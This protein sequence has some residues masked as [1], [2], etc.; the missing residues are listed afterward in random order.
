[1]KISRII[2]STTIASIAMI[3]LAACDPPMPPEVRAVQDE[4]QYTCVDGAVN[5]LA[6]ENMTDIALGWSDSL[7]YNCVDPEPAMSATFTSD[8]ASVVDA[9]I[10]SYAPKCK[11]LQTIPVALDAGV[12]IYSQPDLGVLNVSPEH[13]AGILTGK[14]TDW[15]ELSSDNPGFEISPLPITV[16]PE[17]DEK[18]L[19][20]LLEYLAIA[21]VNIDGELIVKPVATPAVEQYLAMEYGQFAVVPYSYATY[22][23]L[24]AANI[25]LGLDTETEEAKV[26]V[27]NLDG[28][29]SA[30]S[31]LEITKSAT[32][33]S[34]KLDPNKEPVVASGFNPE[35]PYQAIFPVNYYTCNEETLVPRAVGRYIL[36]L[37]QQGGMGGYNYSPLPEPVRVEAAFLIR[38]GLPTPSPTPTE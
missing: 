4:I 32:E 17:A 26:A 16:L 1:M 23:S 34:V 7:L 36:R 13:I 30:A 20:A 28:I 27:P 22:N 29:Q 37:D 2:F 5:I 15:S 24:Y 14:V 31:Q 33:L 18:A 25:F 35:I 11:P 21:K 19:N 9:E 3:A 6:P 8:S 38:Q 10:S 12:L